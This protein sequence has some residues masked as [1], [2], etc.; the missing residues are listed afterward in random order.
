MFKVVCNNY[1]KI[2]DDFGKILLMIWYFKKKKKIFFFRT[3]ERI[4]GFT[5]QYFPRQTSF[6]YRIFFYIFNFKIK[7][8]FLKAVVN[9][10]FKFGEGGLCMGSEFVQKQTVKLP[11]R[12]KLGVKTSDYS[13]IKKFIL[14]CSSI[15]LYKT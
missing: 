8:W 14:R 15:I 9:S 12:G 7:R 2:F 11:A 10:I 5:L 6:F 13:C 4:R 3:D 1:W